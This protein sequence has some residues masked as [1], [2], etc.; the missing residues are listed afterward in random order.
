MSCRVLVVEDDADLREMMAQ[1]LT[2]E[3]FEAGTATD[4]ADALTQLQAPGPHP[5]VILLD[6]MMPRMDGWAFV[7]R[8]AATPAIAAIPVVVVSA[9]PRDRLRGIRA[10][11]VLQKPLNFD[12]LITAVRTHC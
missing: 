11:A 8:Q 6:L 5:H 4:G 7:D 9:A 2:L 12:E 3:G 10:A 1:I